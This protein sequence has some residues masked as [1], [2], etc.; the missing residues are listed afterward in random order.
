M[1]YVIEHKN[2]FIPD[3]E[4]TRLKITVQAMPGIEMEDLN[5]WLTSQYDYLGVE[6]GNWD[7]KPFKLT[8][9]FGQN[10]SP[11]ISSQET[12]SKPLECRKFDPQYISMQQCFVDQFISNDFCPC[13]HKCLPI[14]MEGYRYVR[15]TSYLADCTN[16]KDETCHSGPTSWIPLLKLM[17]SKC[18]KPC[19]SI[20]YTESVIEY[21]SNVQNETGFFILPGSIRTKEKQLLVY[22]FDDMIGSIGGSLGLFLG[23]SFFSIISKC[24]DIL[25]QL[26][27]KIQRYRRES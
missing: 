16:I 7:T 22:D 8:I 23:F 13:Q 6:N 3:Q 11:Q 5:L 26:S 24:I 27:I 18:I 10:Q 4:W 15:N 21:L 9:P 14:H 2:S 17:K 1:C 25:L 12:V 19:K 20:A